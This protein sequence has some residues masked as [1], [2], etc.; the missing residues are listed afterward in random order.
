MASSVGISVLEYRVTFLKYRISH[1]GERQCQNISLRFLLGKEAKIY[2]TVLCVLLK[3]YFN[4]ILLYDS[5]EIILFFKVTVEIS[6][7]I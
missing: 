7:Q 2:H 1:N 6:V 5:V 4:F 3:N